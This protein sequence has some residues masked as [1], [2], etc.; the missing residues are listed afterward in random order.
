[1]GKGHN[2]VT[3]GGARNT[4][5]YIIVFYCCSLK[6]GVGRGSLIVS[7]ENKNKKITCLVK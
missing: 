3:I 2:S 6:H 5:L 1:M 4:S 7:T